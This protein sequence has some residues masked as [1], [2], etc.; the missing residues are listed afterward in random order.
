MEEVRYAWASFKSARKL[1]PSYASND[2]STTVWYDVPAPVIVHCR[3]FSDEPDAEDR[4]RVDGGTRLSA[5]DDGEPAND[6][7]ISTSPSRDRDDDASRSNE[8]WEMRHSNT[9]E[10]TAVASVETD[11]DGLPAISFSFL[12]ADEKLGT[13]R[14]DAGTDSSFYD[15]PRNLYVSDE[16]EI[17]IE[18]ETETETEIVK[19]VESRDETEAARDTDETRVTMETELNEGSAKGPTALDGNVDRSIASEKAE[20][21]NDRAKRSVGSLKSGRKSY[22]EYAE[23]EEYDAGIASMSGSYSDP[24]CSND[25]PSTAS[26]RFERSKV[27]H[28]EVRQRW[29]TARSEEKYRSRAVLRLPE[30]LA[31]MYISSLA[32]RQRYSLHTRFLSRELPLR[33]FRVFKSYVHWNQILIAT[34]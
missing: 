26:R 6:R 9:V 33:I 16:T 32:K 20:D 17:E 3:E 8:Q 19:V 23:Y 30:Y 1:S 5:T 24:E 11:E 2:N 21:R 15:L 29:T 34:R 18:T 10:L 31:K 7:E 13:K 12:R 22:D 25:V 28:S 4:G 14:S 27:A